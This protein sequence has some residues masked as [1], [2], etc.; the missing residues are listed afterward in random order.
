MRARTWLHRAR[1]GVLP[2]PVGLLLQGRAGVHAHIVH[3]RIRSDATIQ[4]LD[5]VPCF[6]GEVPFLTRAEMNFGAACEGMG[7]HLCRL[8]GATKD[9]NAFKRVTRDGFDVALQLLEKVRCRVTSVGAVP[10]HALHRWIVSQ[11]ALDRTGLRRR[12]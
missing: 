7:V 11:G 6:V 3:H 1:Q 5:H 4:L 8:A 10:W 12:G 2:H 9:P